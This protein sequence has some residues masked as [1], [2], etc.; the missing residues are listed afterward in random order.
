[1]KPAIYQFAEKRAAG[2]YSVAG[3]T[4]SAFTLELFL[5]TL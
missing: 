5:F 1:M 4:Q 3:E 2:V